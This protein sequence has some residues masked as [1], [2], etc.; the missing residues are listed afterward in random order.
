MLYQLSYT[1]HGRRS[2]NAKPVYPPATVLCAGVSI[3]AEGAGQALCA[4]A[5]PAAI[6]RADSVSGPGCGTKRAAR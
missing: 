4:G 5:S 2:G 6:A 1:H 3:D